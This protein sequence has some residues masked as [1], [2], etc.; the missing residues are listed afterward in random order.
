MDHHANPNDLSES[1]PG[2]GGPSGLNA[3]QDI[4]PVEGTMQ[5]EEQVLQSPAERVAEAAIPEA[6]QSDEGV[7]GMQIDEAVE[8]AEMTEGAAEDTAEDIPQAL[9]YSDLFRP[10]ISILRSFPVPN[11]EEFRIIVAILGQLQPPQ[12]QVLRDFLV[13]LRATLCNPFDIH[14]PFRIPQLCRQLALIPSDHPVVDIL[15]FFPSWVQSFMWEYMRVVDN[16][17]RRAAARR[18]RLRISYSLSRPDHPLTRTLLT[19][20]DLPN[21]PARCGICLKNNPADSQLVVLPCDQPHHFHR[22]CLSRWVYN[23]ARC[24]LCRTPIR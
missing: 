19:S 1:L 22:S 4:A 9:D 10:V 14:S 21:G 17:V 16:F 8:T 15:N 13:E 18:H 3:V 20:S 6:N 12:Q 11:F 2:E 5:G 23:M 24:P 7:E